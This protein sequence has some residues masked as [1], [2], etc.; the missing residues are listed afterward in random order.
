[1]VRDQE[2]HAPT[3][4][5]VT[6]T[7]VAPIATARRRR[8]RW[9]L[10]GIRVPL[11]FKL[12]AATDALRQLRRS[13][14]R[15]EPSRWRPAWRRVTAPG[16]GSPRS[17]KWGGLSKREE[18]GCPRRS[19]RGRLRRGPP[20][21]AP[22]TPRGTPRH[23]TR[24]IANAMP[25]MAASSR[26]DSAMND[27]GIDD[28]ATPG[29]FIVEGEDESS[30]ARHRRPSQ[31]QTSRTGDD[32]AG[33]STAGSPLPRFRVPVPSRHR[34][35]ETDKSITEAG[36]HW[37]HEEFLIPRLKPRLGDEHRLPDAPGDHPGRDSGGQ[38]QRPDSAIETPRRPVSARRR[39]HR[40]QGREPQNSP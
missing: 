6:I 30:R 3:A 34:R 33:V 1:M 22:R 32:R 14:P 17:E 2:N 13:A 4:Q 38:C 40:N 39:S 25:A 20:A 18:T 21:T 31:D 37:A 26:P 16:A 23:P 15:K 19:R 10:P 7:R 9:A 12:L 35:T 8:F 24:P 11:D 27:Q 28:V 5:T 29:V 36:D